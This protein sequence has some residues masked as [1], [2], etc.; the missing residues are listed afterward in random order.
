MLINL[1]K[2]IKISN[3][4]NLLFLHH[5]ILKILNAR[6]I[7]LVAIRYFYELIFQFLIIIILLIEMMELLFI[8]AKEILSF[9]FF[10]LFM[11]L[12]SFVLHK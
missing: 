9:H 7:I 1:C 6:I 5:N 3:N 4:I 8:N 10:V 12:N 2:P 11:I